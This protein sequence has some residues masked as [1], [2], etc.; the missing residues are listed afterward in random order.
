MYKN[1]RVR[2]MYATY[3]NKSII[4]KILLVKLSKLFQFPIKLFFLFLNGIILYT[5]KAHINKI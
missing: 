5:L 3:I 4:G 2:L 1:I